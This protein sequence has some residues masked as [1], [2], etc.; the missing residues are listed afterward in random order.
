[1]PS[2]RPEEALDA[3]TRPV[4]APSPPVGGGESADVVVVAGVEVVGG[5]AELAEEGVEGE[6][7]AAE[8]SLDAVDLLGL[9]LVALGDGGVESILVG[10]V[11]VVELAGVVG[12]EETLETEA[13][14][15]GGDGGGVALDAFVDV[16]LLLC[17]ASMLA[18]CGVEVVLVRDEIEAMKRRARSGVGDAVGGVDGVVGAGGIA[19][20]LVRAGVESVE[21]FQVA[22]REAVP[23]PDCVLCPV[24]EFLLS[25]GRS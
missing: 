17:L 9:Q 21:L 25:G 12:A 7:G 5:G 13:V 22:D 10:G 3:E 11:E 23:L 19:G 15:V 14:G 8:L 4:R 24:K 18:E 6:S 1:M 16:L 20:D 2:G